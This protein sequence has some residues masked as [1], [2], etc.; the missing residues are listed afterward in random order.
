MNA[1][2]FEPSGGQL[3]V[4]N[5]QEAKKAFD[6]AFSE[7]QASDSY[8][9]GGASAAQ[10]EYL[11]NLRGL[12][13]MV[14]GNSKEEVKLR[15]D[16]EKEITKVLKQQ[17]DQRIKDSTAAATA[18]EQVNA[19]SA[20]NTLEAWKWTHYY[21]AKEQD[22][23]EKHAKIVADAEIAVN[24]MAAQDYVEAWKWAYFYREKRERELSAVFGGAG[25]NAEGMMGGI[26]QSFTQNI[27]AG[28]KGDQSLSTSLANMVKSFPNAMIDEFARVMS[29]SMLEPLFEPFK[30]LFAG[31]G[32]SLR[33]SVFKPAID[34]LKD[35]LGKAFDSLMEMDW[36]SLLGGFS[37]SMSGIA[38]NFT[39][40]LS[41]GML[42]A[43]G[44]FAG[45]IAG[46]LDWINNPKENLS[47]F[48]TSGQSGLSFLS[49]VPVVGDIMDMGSDLL[50]DVGDFFGFAGGT[51]DSIYS[52][53]TLIKVGET[54]SE[55]VTVSPM[56]GAA[57]GESG[58]ASF[59]NQGF[60]V[61]DE[62][63][64]RMLKRRMGGA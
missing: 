26:H 8:S 12:G 3:S 58:G 60:M 54:G 63:T 18:E 32:E 5:M 9:F 1:A 36:G 35:N 14:K 53:P 37:E 40:L 4:A 15:E 7:A 28:L 50:G 52:T 22:A 25:M 13:G 34:W 45:I 6:V 27:A 57:H 30:E 55:R 24:D 61:M 44:P 62:Y 46:G 16:I 56:A 31:V 17:R 23:T 33:D 59:V 42:A 20:Q 29:R 19:I 38:T 64:W 39:G 49:G 47:S 10:S 2:N 21:R 41:E 48:L 51:K 43:A 11:K